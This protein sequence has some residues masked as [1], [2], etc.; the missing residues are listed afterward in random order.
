MY[1]DTPQR[2]RTTA[3]AAARAT[4]AA[5]WHSV[6]RALHAAELEYRALYAAE[7]IDIRALRKAARRIDDLSHL[8]AV[9]AAELGAPPA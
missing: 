1:V 5:R 8:R 7:T 4:L 3:A 2:W 9:L 6:V